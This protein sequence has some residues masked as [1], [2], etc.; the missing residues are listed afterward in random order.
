MAQRTPDK[1]EQQE[2][3]EAIL[4]VLQKVA[5]DIVGLSVRDLQL[6]LRARD[7][8][9]TEHRL[10][11]I[12][13]QLLNEGRIEKR[14][15]PER[16]GHFCFNLPGRG[17]SQMSLFDVQ[18][19]RDDIER[20]ER[21][22]LDLWQSDEAERELATASVMEQIARSHALEENYAKLV[23]DVAP[24]LANENPVDLILQIA[25]WVVDD[26]N[27]LAAKIREARSGA[28]SDIQRLTRELGFRRSKAESFLQRLWRLD[29]SIESVRG[30]LDLPTVPQML[31]GSEVRIDKEAAK[32]RLQERIVGNKVIEIVTVPENPHKAAVGTDA[33]VGDIM[34]EHERGS[35]IPPTPATLFVSAAAM[36]VLDQRSSL[37]YWD[38]DLDPRELRRYGDLDAAVEGLLI[39]PHLRREVIT[40]FRHLRSAAMELRQYAEELRIVQQQSKWHPIG[41]VPEIQHPPA[42]TLLIRDGRIFPLVHRLDDYDGASSP[43]DVL[44]G[45]I[46][47]REIRTFQNVFHN[48]AGTER[49]GAVYAGAV[50]SPEYSWMA[51]ITFWYLYVKGGHQD[52]DDAFYR[53]PLNDQAVIHLLFWGLAGSKPD[54]IFGNPRN[55]F[56]TF[57]ALRRFSD[58]AFFP[59]PRPITD[60]TGKVVRTV[61]EDSMDDW[62]DYIRQHINES[63]QRYVQHKRGIPALTTVD[64]YKPFLHLCHRAGVAMFYAAPARMYA[65]TLN[66]RAH[67]FTPRWEIAVDL[68]TKDVIAEIERRTKDLLAWLVEQD[69]LVPDESHAVG[70]FEEVAEGLPLFIPDVVMEAHKVVGYGRDRHVMD[71]Q[72]ELQRLVTDIR[73]GRLGSVNP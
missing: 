59:H 57:R 33:S 44:Y 39:S 2:L 54:R 67:F 30:I 65:A 64:E 34:V 72:D 35:F 3:A 55:S 28:Q 62:I 19:S 53:P 38:Y 7:L 52:L 9:V 13:G 1:P 5:G 48:T 22:E 32:R 70:G 51:M 26:L 49:L 15:W 10:R 41:G 46:V 18:I 29:R 40:D 23:Y 4:D 21:N 17:L 60:D 66:D 69:G 36:R 11:S 43:D 61:A 27:D 6:Q 73:A 24:V 63:N 16:R 42:I 71:V 25:T 8:D 14:P 56:V 45:E 31:K 68:Q 37:G 58:I 50:K 12:L 47:R 20:E